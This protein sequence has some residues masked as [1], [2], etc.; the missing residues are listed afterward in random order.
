MLKRKIAHRSSDMHFDEGPQSDEHTHSEHVE[1]NDDT[2][3]DSGFYSDN[4]RLPTP[5][6]LAYVT[7]IEDFASEDLERAVV[8]KPDA[9]VPTDEATLATPKRA[10][11][12]W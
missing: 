6:R 3:P 7:A 11:K 5:K 8:E 1:S 10:N 4:I 12:H 2:F 9:R